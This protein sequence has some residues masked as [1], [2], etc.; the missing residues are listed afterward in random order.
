[1]AYGVGEEESFGFRVGRAV[2][3]TEV[4]VNRKMERQGRLEATTIAEVEVVKRKLSLR[5]PSP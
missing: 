3:F 4:N 2:R 5:E 1:M